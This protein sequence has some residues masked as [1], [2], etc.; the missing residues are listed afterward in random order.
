MQGPPGAPRAV[1][2]HA[3]GPARGGVDHAEP[4]Q[5][6]V[7]AADRGRRRA[8]LGRERTDARQR[9]A[10]GE[11]PREHAL[12]EPLG[13]VAIPGHVATS[14]DAPLYARQNETDGRGGLCAGALAAVGCGGDGEEPVILATTTSTQ[15]SGLLDELIPRFEQRV[16]P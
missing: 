3:P 5:L 1:A 10:G 9:R 14:Y 2:G 16:R 13:D 7:R 4:G 15:D 8:G 11:L 6:G 12:H